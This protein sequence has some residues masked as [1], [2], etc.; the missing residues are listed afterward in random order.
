MIDLLLV[1]SNKTDFSIFS[2]EL[3]NQNEVSLVW[4]DSGDDALSKISKQGVDLVITDEKL[5]DMPGLV[6]AEKLV[7][8]N[9]LINCA[10][11][12]ALPEKEF[13]EASEGLGLLAKLP[14]RPAAADARNLLERF[15]M[16]KG[17][18]SGDKR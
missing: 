11:V 1:T 3:V 15:R 16:I 6:F 13:H 14:P 10:V 12:S 8:Q 18:V 9:A 17:M 5:N 4:A 2:Q 7:K